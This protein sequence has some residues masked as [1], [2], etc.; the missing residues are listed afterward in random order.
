MR[1]WQCGS[2]LS[3]SISFAS[4][5]PSRGIRLSQPIKADPLNQGLHHVII[6]QTQ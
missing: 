4:S 5:K 2:L 1:K 6:P 3:V